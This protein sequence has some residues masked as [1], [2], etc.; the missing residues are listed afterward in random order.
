MT[1]AF[2]SVIPKRALGAQ[3]G[4]FEPLLKSKV[5]TYDYRN[6][7]LPVSQQIGSVPQTS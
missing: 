7:N 3:A 5:K 1:P 4:R 6:P 2:Y